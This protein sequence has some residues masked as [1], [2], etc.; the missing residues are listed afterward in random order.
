M[1]SARTNADNKRPINGYICSLE[2]SF[3]IYLTAMRI[4]IIEGSD[5]ISL[6]S[7]D[8]HYHLGMAACSE[9]VNCC[10]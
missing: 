9:K 4:V 2:D 5:L 1:D 3:A 6:R 10:H 7:N 8:I